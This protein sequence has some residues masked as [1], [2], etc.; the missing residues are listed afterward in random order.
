MASF[1]PQASDP[2]LSVE[3]A[4]STRPIT[5]TT[6]TSETPA[7]TGIDGSV[8]PLDK[9]SNRASNSLGDDE[10]SSVKAQKAMPL[11]KLRQNYE[12]DQV[13]PALSSSQSP[14]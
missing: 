2:A 3:Y 12:Q 8:G 7:Q 5:P 4:F 6:Q 9:L 11:S 13:C 14:E 10:A 1:E